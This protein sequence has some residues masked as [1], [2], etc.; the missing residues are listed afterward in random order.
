[1]AA[2]CNASV[3]VARRNEARLEDLRRLIDALE[4]GPARSA[5]VVINER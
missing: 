5:G 1:V 3:V 2:R 4:R